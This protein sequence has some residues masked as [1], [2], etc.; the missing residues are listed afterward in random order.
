MNFDA[1]ALS[2]RSAYFWRMSNRLIQWDASIRSKQQSVTTPIEKPRSKASTTVARTQPPTGAISATISR[3]L[4]SGIALCDH[5]AACMEYG[6]RCL[7]EV[8]DGYV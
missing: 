3:R 6:T 1:S 5:G 7:R 8:D 2:R 4:D